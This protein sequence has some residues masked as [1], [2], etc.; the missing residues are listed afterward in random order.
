[1]RSNAAARAAAALLLTVV[2]AG[3][4]ATG[5]DPVS[6]PATTSPDPSVVPA[7]S[8]ALDCADL[9]PVGLIAAALQGSAPEPV[10]PVVAVHPDAVFEAVLLEGVGGLSCSWRVGA[11]MPVYNSPS[12]WAYLRIAVLPD[13]AADWVPP[14]GHEGGAAPTRPIGDVEAALLA[15]DSGWVLSAPVGAH[16]VQ[17]D[18][19]AAALTASGGRYRGVDGSTVVERLAEVAAAAFTTIAAAPA[20]GFG[21]PL[22]AVGDPAAECRG[23]LAAPGILDAAEAPPGAELVAFEREEPAAS[24]DEAVALRAGTF[25]CAIVVDGYPATV[26]RT[27]RG[28]GGLVDRFAAPDAD[29]SF[30]AVVPADVPDGQ[31]VTAYVQETGDIGVRPLAALAVGDSLHWI[32]GEHA[33]AIAQAIVAQTF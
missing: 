3:C 4:A 19:R 17:L 6:T 29:R 15:G 23:G 9:A 31:A 1:M 33:G 8:G 18:L 28:F 2:L 16:W 14:Q 25:T 21:P 5:A 30:V 26:I 13:A 20:D 12:D 10:A 27:A 32:D 24:F 11:G 7:A 22:V